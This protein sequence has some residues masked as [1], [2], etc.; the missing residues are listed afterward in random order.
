M[1]VTSLFVRMEATLMVFHEN[2]EAPDA[3]RYG[4]RA[5]AVR[6]GLVERVA[7]LAEKPPAADARRHG[8]EALDQGMTSGS[9]DGLVLFRGAQRP[10]F[11]GPAEGPL[12]QLRAGL[13]K[14]IGIA[15]EH[16]RHQHVDDLQMLSVYGKHQ[17]QQTED[18]AEEAARGALEDWQVFLLATFKAGYAIGLI[19]SVIVCVGGQAP[20]GPEG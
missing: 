1:T 9:L 6:E 3:E 20:Q 14:A 10:D 5:A 17:N 8:L 7:A 13:E 4:G 15:D 2:W 12:E 16:W 19:D 11:G 18:E